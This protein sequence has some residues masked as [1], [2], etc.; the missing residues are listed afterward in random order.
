MLRILLVIYVLLLL[1][2]AVYCVLSVV[3]K[4]ARDKL[5]RRLPAWLL[6]LLRWAV[7]SAILMGVGWTIYQLIGSGIS[8]L[9]AIGVLTLIIVVA[10]PAFWLWYRTEM[11]RTDGK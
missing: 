9:D 5:E 8:R 4:K 2:V 3:A 1:S 6:F 7:V 10:G 11:N